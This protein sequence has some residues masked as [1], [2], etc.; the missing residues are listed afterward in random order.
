MVSPT[1]YQKNGLDWMKYH[2][3][4]TGAFMQTDYQQDVSLTTARNPNYWEKGFPYLDKLQMIYVADDLTRV[5]LF[6]SGGCDILSNGRN[7]KLAS[8]LQAQGYQVVVSRGNGSVSMF[9][10]SINADSPWSNL[11]VRMAAEYAIDKEGIA[12]TFG[13]G[14]TSSLNQMNTSVSMAY[15]KTLPGRNYDVAKAKQLL[16]EAGYPNGF[17]TTIIASPMLPDRNMVLVV[18]SFLSKVGIQCDIQFPQAAAYSAISTGGTWNN[19]VLF[20]PTNLWENPNT[21]FNYYFQMPAISNKSIKR[22]DGWKAVLDA[23]MATPVP[24]PALIKQLEDTL[25]NDVTVIPIN[26]STYPWI[27]ADNVHDHGI[28]TYSTD[29]YWEPQYTWLGK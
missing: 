7:P 23:S 5:A 18:Q 16:A 26:D 17:K 1:A 20:T 3:V 13:Y 25:Y 21:V 9:P 2:M 6:K 19:A 15:D 4:G 28:G 8:E 14:Y 12:K 22:P 11:K 29:A 10:D 24:D 27:I